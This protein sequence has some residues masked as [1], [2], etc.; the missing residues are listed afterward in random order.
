MFHF[1]LG[2]QELVLLLLMVVAFIFCCG[3]RRRWVGVLAATM[4]ISVALTSADP[5]S[6]LLVATS[7]SIAFAL[8][9]CA[10]PYLRRANTASTQ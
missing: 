10:A 8:G 6:T 5:F 9:V 3:T 1:G 2:F 4:A 7:L